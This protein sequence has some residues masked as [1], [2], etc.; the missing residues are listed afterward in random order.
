MAELE[1]AA[2]N[3]PCFEE[4]VGEATNCYLT[5]INLYISKEMKATAASL[6]HE[7]GTLLQKLGRNGE[8]ATFFI[9]AAE[10][11]QALDQFHTAI[12]SLWLAV[13]SSILQ[14]DYITS[15]VTLNWIIKLASEVPDMNDSIEVSTRIGIKPIKIDKGLKGDSITEAILTLILLLVLQGDYQQ[16]KDYICK[17]SESS[18]SIDESADDDDD[19]EADEKGS[20]DGEEEEENEEDEDELICKKASCEFISLLTDFVTS[21]ETSDIGGMKWCQRELWQ[22]ITPRQNELFHRIIQAKSH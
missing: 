4:Y 21:C 17:L 3:E 6:Y 18:F 13:D 2:A 1:R 16:S 20:G 9:K 15:C 8:A 10:M 7:L 11:H 5:A 12:A 14:C 22:T 19:D